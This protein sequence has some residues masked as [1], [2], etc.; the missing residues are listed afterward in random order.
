MPHALASEASQA[1]ASRKS[2]TT[3]PPTKAG[4]ELSCVETTHAATPNRTLGSATVPPTV[5][6][7]ERAVFRF[8]VR[9]ACM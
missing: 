8:G 7:G 1:K 9:V 3:V 5:K 2:A 4:D 6:P